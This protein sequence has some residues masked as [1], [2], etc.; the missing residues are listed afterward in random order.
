MPVM[1]LYVVT[2]QDLDPGQ[3]AVQ[4][5]HAL[6]QFTFEYPILGKEWYESS[7]TLSLLSTVDEKTLLRLYKDATE[8]GLRVSMFRE[9]DRENEL[10]AIAIE[11]GP[12]TKRLVA[13]LPLALRRA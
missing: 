1:K 4:A 13:R 5:C 11:P 2:R 8:L 9:P 3:Q 7:N 12:R 10:T 6:T